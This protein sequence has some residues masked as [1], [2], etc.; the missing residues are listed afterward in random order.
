M[1]TPH[2]VRPL[3]ALLGMLLAATLALTGCGASDTASS[4]ADKAVTGGSADKAAAA[5]SVAERDAA[6]GGGSGEAGKSD[7]AGRTDAAGVTEAPRPGVGNV[8]RTAALT[9]RVKSVPKA[10]DQ[11]RSAVEDAGG[12]VGQESTSRDDRGH[13]STRVVLRVPTDAYDEVLAR[14][15]GSGELIRRTARAED[16]TDQVVDVTS[17]IASQRA[18]VSRIRD[19]MDRA[20]KLSDVVTLEGELS[21]READLEALLAQQAS[22]KDRTSLATVTLTL[23]EAPAEEDG[24]DDGPGFR[25]A[26]SGGWHVF[27]TVLRWI[28]LALGAALPF[29]AVAALLVLGWLRAVRPRLSRRAAPAPVTTALGPL[30]TAP[31]VAVDAAG[32]A[33]GDEGRADDGGRAGDRS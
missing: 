13:E 20:D 31:P 25:D 7:A 12:Y 6:G 2:S 11:A 23:S 8:I 24:T 15:Q 5:G 16:V 4:S 26:V 9:V 22:L 27:V 14:L 10:L 17:R 30:P 19:L 32:R 28:A 18:S 21:S 33:H 3:P 29:V 1:R